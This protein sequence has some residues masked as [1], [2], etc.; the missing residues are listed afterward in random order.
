MIKT[1]VTSAFFAPSLFPFTFLVLLALI[2]G[3]LMGMTPSPVEAWPLAWIA[4]APLWFL[5][6]VGRRGDMETWRRGD[7]GTRGTR[8]WGAGELGSWGGKRNISNSQ[9]SILNSQ[10]SIFN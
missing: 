9:F 10:F 3:I 2:G 4:L 7:T 1:Q 5:V 8:R 6:G